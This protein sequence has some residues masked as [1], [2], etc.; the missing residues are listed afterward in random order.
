[1]GMR[2]KET[3]SKLVKI[4]GR[5]LLTDLVESKCF[6][7]VILFCNLNIPTVSYRGPVKVFLGQA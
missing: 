3:Q 1:M 2:L 5:V 4:I 6:S 7:H